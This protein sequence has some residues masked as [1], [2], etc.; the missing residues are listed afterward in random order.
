MIG[1]GREERELNKAEQ[2]KETEQ[3]KMKRLC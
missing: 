1:R 3:I 2:S